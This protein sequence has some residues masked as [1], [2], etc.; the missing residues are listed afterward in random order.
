VTFL[1][2]GAIIYSNSEHATLWINEGINFAI[3][4]I[5]WF[6]L[7]FFFVNKRLRSKYSERVDGIADKVEQKIRDEIL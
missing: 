3:H 6:V 1:L 4:I 5:A 2:I 7:D